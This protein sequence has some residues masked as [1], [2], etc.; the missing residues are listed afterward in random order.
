MKDETSYSGTLRIKNPKTIQSWKDKGLWKQQ[1]DKGFIYAPGCGRF[2]TEIC[3]C[4][5]CRKKKPKKM[6][7]INKSEG[8]VTLFLLRKSHGTGFYTGT[9]LKSNNP[10]IKLYSD[11]VFDEDESDEV[12]GDLDS[13]LS[14]YTKC[15][16][17]ASRSL[18]RKHVDT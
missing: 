1:L 18:Y 10:K 12:E 14:L 17:I 15:K 11:T 7:Y 5:K 13:A 6:L 8:Y 4:T 3:T 9:V 2:R 16:K